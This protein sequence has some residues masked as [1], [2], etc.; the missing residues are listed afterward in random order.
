MKVIVHDDHDHRHQGDRPQKN[1][2]SHRIGSL[3]TKI[4]DHGHEHS[5]CGPKEDDAV[6]AIHGWTR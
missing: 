2:Q 6:K 3:T 5:T 1:T 4:P